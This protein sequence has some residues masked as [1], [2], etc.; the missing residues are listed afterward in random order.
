MVFYVRSY[1]CKCA[2][3]PKDETAEKEFI[4]LHEQYVNFT[5][6]LVNSNRY[7]REDFTVVFQPFLQEM[8]LP[9][10]SSGELDL[11]YYSPDCLHFSRKGQKQ[12]AVSLWNSMFTSV[13]KKKTNWDLNLQ[14]KC[15]SLEKPYLCTRK[16]N[17]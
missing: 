16:N 14:I 13:K 2:L 7:E 4:N 6:D 15:P 17:C 3:Y 9:R 1:A 12:L 10:N 5:R 11:S 8:E